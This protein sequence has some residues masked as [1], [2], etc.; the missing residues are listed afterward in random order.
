MCDF[1][2]LLHYIFGFWLFVFNKKFRSNWLAQFKN[3]E[4]LGK[5]LELLGASISVSIGI[6]IPILLLSLI[7]GEISFF[8]EV[9][10][11]LDAGGSYNY[12]DCSCDFEK[13]HPFLKKHQCI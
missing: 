1:L 8:I 10:S 4:P 2:D 3:K 9:D 5:A 11:C 6:G 12:K 13:N 7:Y